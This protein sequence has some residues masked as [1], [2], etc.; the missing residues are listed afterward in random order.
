MNDKLPDPEAYASKAQEFEQ[1]P[2]NGQQRRNS[3]TKY[4]PEELP[5]RRRKPYFPTV[6]SSDRRVKSALATWSHSKCAYC[7]D[8]INAR[9]SQQVEHFKPKSLFPSLAYDW[10]NYFLACNGCNGTKSDKWPESGKYVRPDQDQPETL[11]AF[12][13]QGGMKARETSSDA[14]RT[15]DD[16]GLDRPGL[17]EARK[18]AI[19]QPLNT[20]RTVLAQRLPDN[21]KRRL[22]QRIVTEAE[23]PEVSYSQAKGQN[24]RRLWHE[25][26]PN[27][28]LF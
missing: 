2:I 9:R 15:V 17:R 21:M 23:H 3:F 20:M 28:S 14:Q 16:F 22:A 6:W 25:H 12:D 27:V 13:E 18:V 8:K 1:L 10:D 5:K 7:E 4:A 24:L 19:R 26:F 11:F